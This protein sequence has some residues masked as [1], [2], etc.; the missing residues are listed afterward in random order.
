MM[1]NEYGAIP[2]LCGNHDGRRR[3]EN[4]EVCDIALNDDGH[5]TRVTFSL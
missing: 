5:L 1:R 2:D 3:V 4:E